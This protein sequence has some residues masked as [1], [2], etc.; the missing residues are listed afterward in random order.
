MGGVWGQTFSL[1]PLFP[2]A[3]SETNS[4]LSRRWRDQYGQTPE[5]SGWQ[6][7]CRDARFS[8]LTFRP[9]EPSVMRVF[10]KLYTD[11]TPP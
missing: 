9:C 10:K 4:W 7:L 2:D 11:L 1:A 6:K 3:V 8:R 5:A